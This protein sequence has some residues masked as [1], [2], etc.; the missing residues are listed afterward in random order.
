MK[1]VSIIRNIKS[2]DSATTICKESERNWE[3]LFVSE[4]IRNEHIVVDLKQNKGHLKNL[5][6]LICQESERNE[7]EFFDIESI[8]HEHIVE[9]FEQNK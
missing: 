6:T 1:T 8:T 2:K 4:S 9:N 3:E 5:T 7:N